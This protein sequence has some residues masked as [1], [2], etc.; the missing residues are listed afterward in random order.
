M[1]KILNLI[2]FLVL[3]QTSFVFAQDE[4]DSGED[5][6]PIVSE[7]D[8]II[9]FAISILAVIGIFLYI[10]RHVILRKKTDYDKKDYESKKD[11]DYEKYHSEWT[12]DDFEFNKNP[13]NDEFKKALQKKSVPNYYQILGVTKNASKNEI[14][15]KFRSLVKEWHPDKNKLEESEKKMADFNKAYE[16]LSDDDKRKLYDTYLDES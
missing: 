6:Q 8:L 15:H 4:L 1:E 12:S 13:N 9:I 3:T 2:F 11:K 10:A 16:I 5:E 14:K 7:T